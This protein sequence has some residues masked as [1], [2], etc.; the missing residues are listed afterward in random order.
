[1]KQLLFFIIF[2]FSLNYIFSQEKFECEKE[3]DS[4]KQNYDR[5]FADIKTINYENLPETIINNMD[6]NKIDGKDLVLYYS[7]II[8]FCP[9]GVPSEVLNCKRF[10]PEIP[11]FNES[12]LWNTKNILLL[13]L[14]I[15]K[16]IVP[17]TSF[18]FITTKNDFVQLFKIENSKEGIMKRAKEIY[19]P[20]SEKH[21]LYFP[22]KSKELILEKIIDYADV[23]NN[24]TTMQTKITNNNSREVKVEYIFEN[25]P[26]L[27]YYQIINYKDNEW[28]LVENKKL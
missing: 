5:L 10:Q 1:M 24:S 8:E 22:F 26:S 21:F 20:N 18:G 15:K 27:N 12:R 28:K 3:Y 25:N 14:K 4:Q 17:K 11:Y 13:Q 9:S 2:I 19:Y 16:N 23:Y 7:N 6:L